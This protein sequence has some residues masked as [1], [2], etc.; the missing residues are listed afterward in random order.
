MLRYVVLRLINAV[1]RALAN[2]SRVWFIYKPRIL[3]KLRIYG[4][5]LHDFVFSFIYVTFFP[6]KT[7]KNWNEIYADGYL[8]KRVFEQ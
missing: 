8:K 6:F 4:W 1:F 5:V 3:Y 2:A 7:T